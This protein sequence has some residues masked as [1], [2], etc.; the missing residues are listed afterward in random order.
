MLS[1]SRSRVASSRIDGNA[2]NSSGFLIKS[3]VISTRIENVIEIAS[4]MSSN[5]AGSGT[6]MIARMASTVAAS[7]ISP[8]INMARRSPKPKLGARCGWAASTI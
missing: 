7:A 3:A 2:V 4:S 8:R 5:I 1:A 6:N